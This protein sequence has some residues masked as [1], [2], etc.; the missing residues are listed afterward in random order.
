MPKKGDLTDCNNWR[1]ISILCVILKVFC[2]IILERIVGLIDM[3]LRKEQA[4]FRA[5]RA[6]NDKIN[7]Q[8]YY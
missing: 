1:G 8:D 5:C 3:N 6:G 2:K 4:G 7:T